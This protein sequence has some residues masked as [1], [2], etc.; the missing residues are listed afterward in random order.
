MKFNMKDG[1]TVILI[2]VAL[3]AFGALLYFGEDMP[4]VKQIREG[5]TD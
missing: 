4:G 3:A 5:F 2:M 1:K